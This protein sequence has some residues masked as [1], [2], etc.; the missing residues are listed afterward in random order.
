[1]LV[2]HGS[3]VQQSTA[4]PR[5][6]V[7][8]PILRPSLLAQPLGACYTNVLSRTIVSSLNDNT[9]ALIIFN[10]YAFQFI[11]YVETM[12]KLVDALFAK[13]IQEDSLFTW[14]PWIGE[15]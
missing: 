12:D 1:M 3:G 8:T 6:R 7:L 11:R 14:P 4:S 2:S 15:M 5:M 10:E 9:I 13:A